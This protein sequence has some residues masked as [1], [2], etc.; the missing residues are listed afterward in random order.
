MDEPV[1]TN[2]RIPVHVFL[3]TEVYILVDHNPKLPWGSCILELPREGDAFTLDDIDT[4]NLC[5]CLARR[6]VQ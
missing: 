4:N 5:V 6:N 3:T 2:H 1:R